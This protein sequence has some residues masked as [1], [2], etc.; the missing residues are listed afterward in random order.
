MREIG[1]CQFGFYIPL[2]EFAEFPWREDHLNKQINKTL[3]LS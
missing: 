3:N 2:L 1:C